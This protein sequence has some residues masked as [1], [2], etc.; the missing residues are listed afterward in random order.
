MA[1]FRTISAAETA[2]D[3]DGKSNIFGW[4]KT[5]AAAT[6]SGVWTDLS[7]APGLP[8]PNYYAAAPLIANTLSGGEG[9]FV[10][11]NVSPSS[12]FLYNFTVATSSA[13]GTPLS[14]ILCDYLLYYPFVDQGTTDAQIMTNTT[15]LPR[16]TDGKGVQIMAVLVAP[17]VGGQGFIVSYTNSDGVAGRTTATVVC[18]TITVNG[19]LVNTATVGPAA[20]GRCAGPF[21][22][23]QPGDSGVR[24]IESVTMLGTDIGLMCL[25]LV[26]PLATMRLQEQGAPNEKDFIREFTQAPCIY[27]G[28]YLNL[29]CCPTGSLSGVTLIGTI[30]TMWT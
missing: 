30:S 4:R 28:A 27:D 1:G 24:S 5:V 16:Y 10:G 21:L 3:A 7:M 26:K 22:P 12:K 11:G 8:L 19:T 2:A 15:T 14:L 17:Q 18:N 23:L 25:V 29:I 9:I 13:T 6:T 20:Q